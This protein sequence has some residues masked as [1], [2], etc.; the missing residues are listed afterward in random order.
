M[1]AQRA[2]LMIPGPVDV[3][4]DVL[5][6]L[7]QPAPPHYGVDW[8]EIYGEVVDKLKQVFRTRNDL[9][10][11]AGAGTTG[12]DAA[13]G[14]LMRTGDEVLVGVNGFFGGRLATVAECYGLHVHTIEAP[15]GQPLDPQAFERL[16]SKEPDIQA[17]VMVHLET[18]TGVLNPLQEIA[19]ISGRHGVP[20]VVDAVSSM[21]GIPV[22]VDEWGIDI[23]VTVTNKCLGCPPGV[24]PLSVSAKAWE[25][26][27]RKG[28]R[29]HGWY[30]NLNI[31]REYAA[32]W[33]TWHPYPTSLPTNN[34]IA[35][36]ASLRRILAGGLEAYYEHHV[37]A[38]NTVRAGLHRLGF[39][40]FT[41]EACTSPL[42]STVRR[43]RWMD[44]ADYRRFLLEQKGI[45]IA[46]GLGA[47]SDEIFRLGHIG[48]AASQ[49]YSQS[50]L[51]GTEEYLR[52]KGRPVPEG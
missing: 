45:M 5:E 49:E 19:A 50:F 44:I 6:A 36:R 2:R 15:P 41:P 33:A 32:D 43:P 16:L 1:T 26:M 51:S 37:Q 52:L 9:F 47:L 40:L 8:L 12:L 20:I 11:M 31:W 27:D 38:A 13:V 7:A 48:R 46:G 18:S 25:Q 22:N 14:S 4:E 23:C 35:L 24:A 42:I 28:Q 3:E 10:L 39:A 17:V 30:Q 29:A 34:I 21:G